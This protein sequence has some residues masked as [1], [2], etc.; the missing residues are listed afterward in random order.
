MKKNTAV[1]EL[2]LLY[3]YIFALNNLKKK[4]IIVYTCIEW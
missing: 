2:Q 4:H 1:T 3:K